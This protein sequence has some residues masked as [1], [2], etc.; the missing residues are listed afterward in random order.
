MPRDLSP[1]ELERKRESFWSK[2]DMTPDDQSCWLWKGSKD[3]KGYGR[4]GRVIDG[5]TVHAMAHRTA[6]L[7]IGVEIPAGAHVLH[8][9][10]VPSCCNPGHLR[11]GTNRENMIDRSLRRRHTWAHGER[12]AKSKLTVSQVRSIRLAAL[13]GV[14]Y[15]SIASY[16][17][18]C[19][20]TVQKV[21]WRRYWA[22]VV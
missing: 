13:A 17:G 9:C 14:T 8:S 4:I 16:M 19:I 15:Q 5:R 2:V 1:S 7:M 10:D 21:V 6:L 11:A 18:V 3:P 12:N 20:G 22:H